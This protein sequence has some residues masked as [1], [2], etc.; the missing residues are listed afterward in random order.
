MKP[1]LPAVSG[2]SAIAIMAAL[3]FGLGLQTLVVVCRYD[4]NWSRLFTTG[5][6]FPVPP[7]LFS[8]HLYVFSSSTGYDGQ[9]YH[10]LTHDAFL[11]SGFT[12]TWMHPVSAA[13]AF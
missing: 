2:G 5:S 4:G 11:Q 6:Y 7:E 1:A 3:T 13:V 10:Y 12:G 9:M 8:E